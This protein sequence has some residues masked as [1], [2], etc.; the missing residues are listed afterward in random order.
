MN[1]L[2]LLA[3]LLAFIAMLYLLEQVMAGCITLYTNRHPL[4][5]RLLTYLSAERRHLAINPSLL[6]PR[7]SSLHKD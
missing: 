2:L 5:T 6:P 3:A 4:F 7:H 1:P